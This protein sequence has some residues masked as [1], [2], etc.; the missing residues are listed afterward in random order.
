MDRESLQA[1]VGA[2]PRCGMLPTWFND[3]PLRAF[4][5][6]PDNVPHCEMSRVVPDPAQP[7]DSVA[8][9]DWVQ[10]PAYEDARTGKIHD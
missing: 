10:G 9:S 6:G 2:C 3:V 1:S 8:G 7:Y 4:C 5:W